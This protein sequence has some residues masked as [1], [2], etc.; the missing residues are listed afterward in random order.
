MADTAAVPLAATDHRRHSTIRFLF[1]RMGWG[2]V[3]L[4]VLTVLTFV[5]TNF[6][7]AE[8]T[9]RALLGRGASDVQLEAFAREH[10]L[11]RPLVTRFVDWLGHILIG[12]WGSSPQ[13]GTGVLEQIIPRLG[14][15]VML[16]LL[17]LGVS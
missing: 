15:T 12:D 7:S 10:G 6:R 9:A 17:A 13:T 16:A 2:L 11:Y 5:A 1:A 4:F 14:N 8:E 3:T